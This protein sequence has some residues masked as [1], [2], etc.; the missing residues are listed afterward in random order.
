[1]S[2]T[3]GST[4]QRPPVPTGG[5]EPRPLE[6]SLN[7][8]DGSLLTIP[9]SQ[10]LLATTDSLYQDLYNMAHGEMDVTIAAQSEAAGG[11][12]DTTTDGTSGA[13]GGGGAGAS[14]SGGGGGTHHE[15]DS[16]AQATRRE[17]MS[18]LSFAQRRHELAWRLTQHG[19]ALQQVAGLTAAT[20]SSDFG[21]QV[22]VSST[23]L[24]HARTAWVQADEA[25]DA[26]YFF[27]AQLF[28]A[29]AAPHDVYG[30]LDVH[31]AGQWYDLPSDL[32]LAADRY[33]TCPES[34]YSKQQVKEHW[35]MAV[36]EKLLTG[37]VADRKRRRNKRTPRFSLSLRGG[38]LELRH[39]TPRRPPQ[40]D[41]S[42]PKQP[43]QQ[44]PQGLASNHHQ[45][46]YPIQALLTLVSSSSSS[47]T[48]TNHHHQ[49][50]NNNNN[51]KDEWTLLSLDVRVQAKTGEFNHQLEASNRQRYDLH[52]LAALA[53]TREEARARQVAAAAQRNSSPND[54]TA[55]AADQDDDEPQP[56]DDAIARPLQ[57]LFDVAQEFSLSWQ[58]EL[59]S[60]QALALRRGAWSAGEGSQI[61]VTPVQFADATTLDEST[62]LLG[63]MSISFW[64]VDDA[65]GPPAMGDLQP[66]EQ[67]QPG[68]EREDSSQT[69]NNNKAPIPNLSRFNDSQSQLVLSIRA[70][71]SRGI[72]VALSGGSTIRRSDHEKG[73]APHVEE[74]I[75]QLLDAASNPF[76]LSASDALLAATRLCTERKC[77]AVVRALLQTA[78][79]TA[80]ERF[81]PPWIT[82]TAERGDISIAPRVSYYYGGARS[83]TSHHEPTA[84]GAPVLFR[85]ACDARTGSFVPTFP[86]TMKLLRY[87]AC[88]DVQASESLALR[89][90]NTPLNRRRAMG[91]KS[92]GFLVKE[93]FDGLVRSMNVLGQRVGVGGQWD[94]KDSQSA[95]I[96]DRSIAQACRDVTISMT[97]CC[98]LVALFGLAPMAIGTSL[99]MNAVPDVAGE[100]LESASGLT[101]FPT[102]PLSILLDQQVIET[103]K[104]SSD[105][106]SSKRS[107][108]QQTLFA[109][110]FAFDNEALTLYPMTI[111]VHLD[112]PSSVPRRTSC[113][114][115]EFLPSD[116]TESVL[117]PPFKRLKPSGDEKGSSEQRSTEQEDMI[118][119]VEHFASIISS[120]L[121][122]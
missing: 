2:S 62:V 14:S 31:L 54:E 48:S 41:P 114:L 15:N 22:Q 118:R 110:S 112:T 40:A 121:L 99:G 85:L 39:G 6:L 81:L 74:T 18:N 102:P 82:L 66:P 59:L 88:N 71:K 64:R 61:N 92:T 44:Q 43:Q 77:D 33:E 46:Q 4:P 86:R 84:S 117:E 72:R 95:S 16:M 89:I 10:V 96:R 52:R 55:T 75:R 113:S 65:Y 105:G 27:H 34:A 26:M 100:A 47:T 56:H 57:A 37:E 111:S 120:T 28:P 67:E 73:T 91:A 32:R 45:N 90:A 50:N 60:A 116:A 98:G 3:H 119:V 69:N 68:E 101:L 29:R 23:A 12:G 24:Q 109:L 8:V 49:D 38:V 42:Q 108:L 107:N 5:V 30:A 9:L 1:M 13:G 36:R 51:N 80:A 94:D 25:Q 106:V 115:V 7:P 97:K 83:E 70:E 17:R 35:Q 53:M 20:A 76:A 58:L 87:L 93:A 78:G 103:T 11:G 63:A 122:A 21:Q 104:S 19:R 79:G